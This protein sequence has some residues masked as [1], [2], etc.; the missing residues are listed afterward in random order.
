M[1]AEGAVTWQEFDHEG[2]FETLRTPAYFV[3]VSKMFSAWEPVV[4]WG[5]LLEGRVGDEVARSSRDELALGLNY[6][7]DS[8]VPLKLAWVMDPD[9]DDRLLLQLGFGF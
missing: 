1:K 6:W 7:V 4:R 2:A 3:Q 5:Q 9:T 8:S